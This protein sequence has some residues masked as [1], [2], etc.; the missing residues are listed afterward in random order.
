MFM[1]LKVFFSLFQ[2]KRLLQ[3]AKIILNLLIFS[4]SNCSW[5]LSFTNST[6]CVCVD[7][8]LKKGKKGGFSSL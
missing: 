7:D 3:N 4:S 8:D 6:F 1:Q 2:K 5:F